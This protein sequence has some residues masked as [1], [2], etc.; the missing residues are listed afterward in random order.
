MNQL[1]EAAKALEKRGF[2]VQICA[3]ASQAQQQA[4]DIIGQ[5]SAGFGG[6]MTLEELGLFDI[7]KSQGNDVAWHWKV[8]AEETNAERDA[9]LEKE[10]YLTSANAICTDGKI[11]NIDGFGNRVAGT[12]YGPDHVLLIAGRNKI[13]DGSLEDAIAR[14]KRDACVPNAKRLKRSTPCAITGQCTDCLAPD[15]MCHVTVILE[16]PS[17]HVKTF[18]ILLVDDNLGY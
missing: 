4:L 5:S 9:A 11:I 15:R 14:A 6:S 2:Q 10:F 7:L 17:T 13:V 3:D 8:S 12:F 16:G 18:Y 1:K